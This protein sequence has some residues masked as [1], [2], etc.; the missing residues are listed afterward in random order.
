MGLFD[1]LFG[2]SKSEYPT[3]DQ[4]SPAAGYLK[5][6]Q[7]PLAQLA[8]EIKDPLEVVPSENSVFVFI[9]KPPKKFGVAWIEKDGRIVNFKSLVDERGLS[10]ISLE[11]LSDRLKDVYSLHMSEPRFSTHIGDRQV[12]VIPSTG[13]IDGVRDVV[14]AALS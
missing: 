5:A 8:A 2:S 6:Q 9:G 7:Q 4:A 11:R 12:V 10:M 14:N 13:L 3:L 1:K